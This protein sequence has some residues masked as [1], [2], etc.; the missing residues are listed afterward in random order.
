[1]ALFEKSVGLVI[2]LVPITDFTNYFT[3]LQ[4]DKATLANISIS[5]PLVHTS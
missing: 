1:M 2:K 4:K 3:K 5:Y